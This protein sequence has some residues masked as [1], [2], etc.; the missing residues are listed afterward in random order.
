MQGVGC[1][2]FILTAFPKKKKIFDVHSIASM[3]SYGIHTVPCILDN[4]LNIIQ[5]YSAKNFIDFMY[6]HWSIRYHRSDRM[7]FCNRSSDVLQRSYGVIEEIILCVATHHMIWCRDLWCVAKEHTKSWK[8]NMGSFKSFLWSFKRLFWVL[9]VFKWNRLEVLE[10]QRHRDT[11][12]VTGT[13]RY[14][15]HTDMKTH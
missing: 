1:N 6:Y 10:T 8:K 13:H 3:Q 9:Q 5:F 7:P 12:T 15:N 4:Y 2:T 11:E 14:K